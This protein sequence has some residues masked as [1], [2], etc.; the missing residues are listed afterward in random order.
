MEEYQ[1]REY[2]RDIRCQSQVILDDEGSNSLARR[3]SMTNCQH[4]EAYVFHKWLQNNGYKILK[5]DEDEREDEEW[6]YT[7]G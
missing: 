4:C 2:C 6:Q 3:L 1:S 5:I 7:H